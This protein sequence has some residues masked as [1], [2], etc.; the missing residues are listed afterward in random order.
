[1]L[2]DIFSQTRT[3]RQ[4]PVHYKALPGYLMDIADRTDPFRIP[5]LQSSGN[6]Q[7]LNLARIAV[8]ANVHRQYRW[9]KDMT[10]S[11]PYLPQKSQVQSAGNLILHWRTL[12]PK[13][14]N[15]NTA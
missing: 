7:T 13:A 5:E 9:N 11:P 15:V 4:E 8:I 12:N 6:V 2:P 1:M 14:V 3:A 10:S